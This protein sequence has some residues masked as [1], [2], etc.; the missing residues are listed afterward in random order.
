MN[1]T[2]ANNAPFSLAGETAVVTGGGTGLGMAIARCLT[3][4]GAHVTVAGRRKDVI[5]AAARDI[6]G[7]AVTCD[8]TEADQRAALLDT[9]GAPSIVVNNAGVHLG[10]PALQTDDADFARVI[11][12]HVQSSFALSRDAAQRLVAEKRGGSMVFVSSMA[13]LFGIPN[14]AAYSAAKAAVDGLVRCL[15]VEWAEHGIRVNSVAPGWI[16]SG[17][18]REALAKN[19]QRKARILERTPMGRLGDDRDIGWAVTYL[20]SPAARF[21][22][23]TTHVVDG[24]AS[25]GF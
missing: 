24:G 20:C 12:T 21:V 18:A 5:E 14:V 19:P 22:T 3:E 7:E 13:A 10:K 17:M 4:A 6:G 25:I 9:V 16:D 23:G 1:R 15:A 8:V 2:Q 11:Q